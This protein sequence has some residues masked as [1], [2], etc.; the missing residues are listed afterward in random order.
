VPRA[1]LGTVGLILSTY[2]AI[3]IDRVAF[4]RVHEIRTTL[5]AALFGVLIVAALT[6]AGTTPVGR[7]FGGPLRTLGKYSYGLY[8]FHHFFSYYFV[9]HKTEFIVA[10]WVGSHTLAVMLQASFGFAASLAVS[11]A[12]Y[13]LFEK[14]FLSLKRY[15]EDSASH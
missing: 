15:W 7:L 13:H 9:H 12:S 8:V 4:D 5:F 1:A 14:R 11:Y 2:A 6:S 3:K 10:R